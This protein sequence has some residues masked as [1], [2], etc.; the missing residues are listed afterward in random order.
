MVYSRHILKLEPAG[1][2]EVL[3]VTELNT[4]PRFL[5]LAGVG[6]DRDGQVWGRRWKSWLW[7]C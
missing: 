5:A 3:G 7:L 1:F 2:I 6:V 4:T